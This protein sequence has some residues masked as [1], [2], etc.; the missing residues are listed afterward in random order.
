M[1]IGK[2]GRRIVQLEINDKM[3]LQHDECKVNL[4]HPGIVHQTTGDKVCARSKGKR[5]CHEPQGNALYTTKLDTTKEEVQASLGCD[6]HSISMSRP[7]LVAEEGRDQS[8][9]VNKAGS[10]RSLNFASIS[11]KAIVSLLS[12]DS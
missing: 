7:A 12:N 6:L 8:G 5:P 4:R 9:R 3:G 1:D 11:L 10:C 2:S